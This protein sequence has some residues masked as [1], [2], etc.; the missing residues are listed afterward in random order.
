MWYTMTVVLSMFIFPVL[1]LGWYRW[2]SVVYNDC[3]AVYVDIPC[4][5]FRLV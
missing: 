5:M 3:G 1:C 2:L 4:P